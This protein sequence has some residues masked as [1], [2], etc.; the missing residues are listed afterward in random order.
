MT[1][2][3]GDSMRGLRLNMVVV[4]LLVCLASVRG[5]DVPKPLGQEPSAAVV[6]K[7]YPGTPATKDSP[8]RIRITAG[9]IDD[10]LQVPLFFNDDASTLKRETRVQLAQQ[11]ALL[12]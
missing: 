5:E 4:A 3:R 7:D 2:I 9:K 10:A 6:T 11:D 8:A 1:I 12:H